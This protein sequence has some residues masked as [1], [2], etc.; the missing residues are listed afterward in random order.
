MYPQGDKKRFLYQMKMLFPG[1]LGILSRRCSLQED[2]DVC[3]AGA[4]GSFYIGSD[5]LDSDWLNEQR[6]FTV[7]EGFCLRTS[8]LFRS[9]LKSNRER[10]VSTGKETYYLRM[11]KPVI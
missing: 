5:N 6:F 1:A 11:K 2:V 7:M 3:R 8:V 9:K 4:E 10:Y